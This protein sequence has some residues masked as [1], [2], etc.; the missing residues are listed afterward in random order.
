MLYSQ[1]KLILALARTLGYTKLIVKGNV[2]TRM[3]SAFLGFNRLL[4]KAYRGHILIPQPV[5]GLMYH[6]SRHFGKYI[7]QS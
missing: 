1:F 3:Y 6:N 4:K 5:E 7:F 2:Y